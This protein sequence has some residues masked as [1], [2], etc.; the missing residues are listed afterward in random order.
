M[1]LK[2]TIKTPEQCPGR[3]PGVFLIN[4]D[5]ILDIF[6]GAWLIYLEQVNAEMGLK[7]VFYKKILIF[8]VFIKLPLPSENEILASTKFDFSQLAN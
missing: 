7:V 2:L 4:F 8:V 5:H 3:R 1:C 6:F